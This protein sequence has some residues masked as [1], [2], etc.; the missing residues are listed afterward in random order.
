[1]AISGAVAGRDIEIRN[2]GG[3][4]TDSGRSW[5]F[6]VCGIE[7]VEMVGRQCSDIVAIITG[8]PFGVG[9]MSA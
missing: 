8:G 2:Q 5:T 6:Q 7:I 1:M 9:T 4:A 3:A